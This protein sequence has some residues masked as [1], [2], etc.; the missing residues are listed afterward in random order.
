MWNAARY[1][2]SKGVTSI[3]DLFVGPLLFL[4]YKNAFAVNFLL[5]LND[6]YMLIYYVKKG[7]LK[8]EPFPN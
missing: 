8:R 4:L 5:F 3:Q 1:F 6:N 7:P 2:A